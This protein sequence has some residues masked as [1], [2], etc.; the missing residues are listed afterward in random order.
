[1]AVIRTG[2]GNPFVIGERCA[3]EVTYITSTKMYGDLGR[4]K[5]TVAWL[6]LRNKGEEKNDNQETKILQS[7]KRFF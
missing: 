2:T 3:I 1:M 4:L 7:L 6:R 5:Y